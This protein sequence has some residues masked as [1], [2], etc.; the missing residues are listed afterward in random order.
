[1][2]RCVLP[3]PHAV[4]RGA[5]L[6]LPSRTVCYER[7]ALFREKHGLP[8]LDRWSVALEIDNLEGHEPRSPRTKVFVH[9]VVVLALLPGPDNRIAVATVGLIICEG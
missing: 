5:I 6:W 1:M 3:Y 2:T 9:P 7:A 4:M 8:E